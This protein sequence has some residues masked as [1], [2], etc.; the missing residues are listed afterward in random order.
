MSR[1]LA[2]ERDPYLRELPVEVLR[3]DEDDTGAYVLLSD[4]I[5][6]PEGGG[7]PADRGALDAHVSWIVAF[8]Q[9]CERRQPDSRPGRDG[10]QQHQR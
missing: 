8:R 1:N 3:V 4:T 2:F 10:G 5:L 6:Y 7:Q 9:H